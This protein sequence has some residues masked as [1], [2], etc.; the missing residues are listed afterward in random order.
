MGN[1]I[2]HVFAQYG[3]PVN[4]V[5]LTDEVLQKALS[6]IDRNLSRQVNKSIITEDTRR[7][8]LARIR[9]ITRISDAV[10]NAGLVVEAV[11]E[12]EKLKRSVFRELDQFA[13]PHCILATNTSSISI[14]EIAEGTLRPDKVIGMHFMNPVP[15]MKLVEVIRGRHTSDETTNTVMDLAR[16]LEKIPVEVN[17]APGFISNRI[18]MP[19][20]NEAVYALQE[21]V[22]GVAEIDQVMKLGMSHPL[23]PLQLADLIGLDVCLSIINVLYKGFGTEK[24]KTCPLLQHLVNANQMGVKTGAGFYDYTN[25]KEPIPK[26]FK[27]QNSKLTPI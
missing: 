12:I 19:M 24:Y 8:A 3:F 26:Q 15:V 7:D 27:I 22:A 16:R 11:P 1:G 6:A 13:P 25:P 17:D 20:I 21:G 18:L 14:T 10:N 9:P 23:G 5:D 4:L 2:A